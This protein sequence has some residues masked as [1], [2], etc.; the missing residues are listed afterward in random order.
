MQSSKSYTVKIN[1]VLI[2]SDEN[3]PLLFLSLSLHVK[4]HTQNI[5]IAERIFQ[6]DNTIWI[7]PTSL[8]L[9]YAEIDD[10]SVTKYKNV[11]YG[12]PTA[13]YSTITFQ[14]Y[15]KVCL[16]QRATDSLIN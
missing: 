8:H 16:E 1:V 15:P 7:S 11:V 6:S 14:S 5:I 9:V 4:T 2:I 12:N 10:A 13:R 3:I